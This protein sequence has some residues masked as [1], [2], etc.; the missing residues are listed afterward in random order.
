MARDVA[1]SE[2]VEGFFPEK[3][4]NASARNP[5]PTT[6]TPSANSLTSPAAR[7]S[8]S[9]RAGDAFVSRRTRR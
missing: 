8:A 9:P 6:P 1:L 7:S 4:A 2:A 3:Q 5:L